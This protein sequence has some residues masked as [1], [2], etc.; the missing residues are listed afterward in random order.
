ME[1]LTGLGE[2]GREGRESCA[3]VSTTSQMLCDCTHEGRGCEVWPTGAKVGGGRGLRLEQVTEW[4]L[5][6]ISEN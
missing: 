5:K 2:G 4:E 1:R 3:N 6:C